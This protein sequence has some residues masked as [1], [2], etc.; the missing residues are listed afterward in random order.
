VSFPA[1]S[2]MYMTNMSSAARDHFKKFIEDASQPRH[3][4]GN[5]CIKLCYFLEQCRKSK[6]S[7]L[8]NLAYSRET[9]QDLL[10]FYVE[11]NEKNQHRSM[12]QVL[13]L[14]ASLISLNPDETAANDFKVEALDRLISI[15]THQSAQPLV[16]PAFKTLECFLSKRIFNLSELLGRYVHVSGNRNLISSSPGESANAVPWDRFVSDV[17]EWMSLPD[18]ASAAGKLLVSLFGALKTSSIEN[19]EKQNNYSLYW[20]RWIQLGLG[21]YPE[22]LENVKNYLFPPLFKL[23]RSGSMEFLRNLSENDTIDAIGNQEI[24]SQASL[25]LSAM[26]VGKK[27][28]L[29]DD[30][31]M[32]FYYVS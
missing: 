21:R 30:A 12:R 13:E 19:L 3:I 5:A 26:D 29:V 14:L 20:Q 16:K 23:D 32:S 6:S 9:C 10:D 11:W 8:R 28:G 2:T 1:F 27:L 18:T 15:I 7:S 25:L 22:S 24:D 17:F 31:G 4:S